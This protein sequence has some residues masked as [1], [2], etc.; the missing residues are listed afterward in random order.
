M[1]FTVEITDE[2]ILQSLLALNLE[3]S[4]PGQESSLILTD[5]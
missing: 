1:Q 5:H 4:R 3:R 2:E